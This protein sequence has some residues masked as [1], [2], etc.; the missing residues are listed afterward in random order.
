MGQ[1]ALSEERMI[2]AKKNA[3]ARITGFRAEDIKM[4]G[5]HNFYLE[6]KGFGFT[7][8][9]RYWVTTEDEYADDV[10][11]GLISLDEPVRRI[12]G[13]TVVAKNME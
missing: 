7:T 10:R 13:F 8:K 5:T 12:F 4:Q 1:N 11:N 6:V 3:I 9:A 2:S